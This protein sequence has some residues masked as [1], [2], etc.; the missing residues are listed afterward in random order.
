MITKPGSLVFAMLVMVCVLA[1]GGCATMP[2]TQEMSDARQSVQAAADIGADEL[3]PQNLAAAREYLE[4]AERELE[5]RF[6]SRARQ[7]AMIAK[8]EAT[9][10]HNVATAIHAAR[11]AIDRSTVR[12]HSLDQAL[13]LL[14]EAGEAAAEGRVRR[15][16]RLAEEARRI[17][18]GESASH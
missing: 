5:M 16:I 3:A 1:L 10:A 18:E 17:A 8:N 15:A 11:D 13:H 4:R 6:F 7:E 2:P 12:Q 14:D 9:K